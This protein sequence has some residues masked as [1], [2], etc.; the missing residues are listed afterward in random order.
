MLERQRRRENNEGLQ[1]ELRS[2]N[3][4]RGALWGIRYSLATPA[5]ADGYFLKELLPMESLCW[6]RSSPARLQPGNN[7][8]WSRRKV[9][10]AKKI[11]MD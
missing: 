8:C 1:E 5:G 6:S 11:F 9:C 2:G 4:G 7:P 3:V 10:V